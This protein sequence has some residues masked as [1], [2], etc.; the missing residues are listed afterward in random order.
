[1]CELRILLLRV[2][3]CGS[4]IVLGTDGSGHDARTKKL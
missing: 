4:I 3:S 1:M 2:L